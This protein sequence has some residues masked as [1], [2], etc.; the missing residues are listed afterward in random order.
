MKN[1]DFWI[2][3]YIFLIF[4]LNYTFPLRYS[5]PFR[6][7]GTNPRRSTRIYI[8]DI[9]V[10]SK[11]ILDE[12]MSS[13][14][15]TATMPL[16]NNAEGP[17]LAMLA[18]MTAIFLLVVVLPRHRRSKSYVSTG[19]A[20]AGR[21]LPPGPPGLPV[22]GN[23]HQMLANKPVFRW[24]HRLLKH[25]GGEIVRVRLGPVHVVVVT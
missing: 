2:Y 19:G 9:N 5:K 4:F 8:Y 23:M 3:L 16:V 20:T 11:T 18:A 10:R 13:S 24:L 7:A 12:E 14:N 21:G 1:R 17:A 6:F 15:A 25:F 22:V